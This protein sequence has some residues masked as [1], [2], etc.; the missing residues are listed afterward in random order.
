MVDFEE[1]VN[2]FFEVF[3]IFVA[4]ATFNNTVLYKKTQ[5]FSEKS[6]RI[7]YNKNMKQWF[8]DTFQ[9]DDRSN[10]YFWIRFCL[11]IVWLGILLMQLFH[12]EKVPQLLTDTYGLPLLYTQALAIAIV[13]CEAAMLPALLSARFSKKIEYI[14]RNAIALTMLIWLMACATALTPFSSFADNSVLL[15]AVAILPIGGALAVI[16]VSIIAVYIGFSEE[17]EVEK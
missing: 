11:G 15:G 12:F 1:R 3:F 17:L 5:A 16:G 7:V 10:A 4:F 13:V 6:L 8:K 2:C 9:K 14:S